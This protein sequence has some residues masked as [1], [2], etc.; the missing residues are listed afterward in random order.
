M[1]LRQIRLFL[2]PSDYATAHVLRNAEDNQ[3]RLTDRGRIH[4]KKKNATII[5]L[6]L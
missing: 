1:N 2:Y 5:F 6:T 4:K 3:N